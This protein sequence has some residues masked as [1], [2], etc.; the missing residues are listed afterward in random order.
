M[1]PPRT[2]T[3]YILSALLLRISSGFSSQPAAAEQ[4]D[5]PVTI[6]SFPVGVTPYALTYDGANIWTANFGS[7]DVTKLRASDGTVQ[8]TFSVGGINP[9]NLTFDGA[10][11]WTTNEGTNTVTKLRASDGAPLGI[12]PV[13]TAPVGIAYDGANLWV[14]NFGDNTVTELRASDGAVLGTLPAGRVPWGVIFD[15]AD[16]WIGS[17]SGSR[18]RK[19]RPSD[20]KLIATLE[21][22]GTEHR[23]FAFDGS[24][25]WI[26]SLSNSI[27]TAV[28]ARDGWIQGT[29]PVGVAPWG[30]AFDG[31]QVWTANYFGSSVTVLRAADGGDPKTFSVEAAPTGIIYD[32]T[33]IWVACSGSKHRQQDHAKVSVGWPHSELGIQLAHPARNRREQP[34]EPI[35]P[36]TSPAAAAGCVCL[37]SLWDLALQPGC[38]DQH[39]RRR[40]HKPFLPRKRCRPTAPVANSFQRDLGF[41]VADGHAE[42][43]DRTINKLMRHP[44]GPIVGRVDGNTA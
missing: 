17:N 40:A 15:G 36:S 30:V 35:L 44:G 31:A 23:G 20:G 1:N 16:I 13:G 5:P 24:T 18:V 43:A 7:W 32:G 11:I 37:T 2:V 12:F 41:G 4:L 3:V 22:G 21:P 25:M 42:V 26:A 39:R 33:S 10:N 6:H 29:F 14:S 34:A 9:S 19:L 28:R 8:G 38:Q 27:V